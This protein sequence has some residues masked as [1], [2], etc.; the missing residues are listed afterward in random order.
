M[1]ALSLAGLFVRIFLYIVS[2]T[3]TWQGLG[4]VVSSI[5]YWLNFCS[6]YLFTSLSVFLFHNEPDIKT[7]GL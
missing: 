4:S 7:R 3:E 2:S 1:S 5:P 6:V